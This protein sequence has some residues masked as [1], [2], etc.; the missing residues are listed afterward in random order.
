MNRSAV[1]VIL[2]AELLAFRNRLT[3]GR[4]G[5]LVLIAILLFGMHVAQQ[6]L[7]KYGVRSH[8]HGRDTIIQ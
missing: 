6:D 5:R 8:G 7:N 2:S 4:P 3:K 1:A